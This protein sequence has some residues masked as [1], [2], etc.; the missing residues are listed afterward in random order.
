[1]EESNSN[2]QIDESDTI[3]KDKVILN[4]SW[5]FWE[6]Y[7]TKTSK[8]Y[9]VK[10]IYNFDDLISFWQFWNKY[11]GNETKKI[12]YNGEC[13]KYFFKEKY[14]ISA[15]NLFEKGIRPEW[16]DDKNNGGN[17]LTLEYGAK[18]LEDS[19]FSILTESWVK[20]MCFLIGE[21]LPHNKYINGIR[22][23][24]KSKLGKFTS[25]RF[26]IWVNKDMKENEINELK[27]YLYPEFKC[28]ATVKPMKVTK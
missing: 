12:F 9:V 17:T 11:P 21:T 20:L 5:S 13:I 25:F 24:D 26:E 15:I 6:N 7:E 1:M 8:S 16:E 10:E 3:E 2:L 22:F 14:R 23:V 18:E 27:K 4:R 28:M 19:F